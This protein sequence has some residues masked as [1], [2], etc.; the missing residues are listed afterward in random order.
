MPIR[1]ALIIKADISNV[2]EDAEGLNCIAVLCNADG[3]IKLVYD[4]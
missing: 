1:I 4:T 3:N 2:G